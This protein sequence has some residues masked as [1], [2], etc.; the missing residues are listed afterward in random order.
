MRNEGKPELALMRLTGRYVESN[1][2][3]HMGQGI[4]LQF[5]LTWILMTRMQNIAFSLFKLQLSCYLITIKLQ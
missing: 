2:A 3:E 1:I 5:R 4:P